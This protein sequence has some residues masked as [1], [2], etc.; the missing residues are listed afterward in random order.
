MMHAYAKMDRDDFALGAAT[1]I[2]SG[3]AFTIPSLFL[4]AFQDQP[5]P[6]SRLID[7]EIEKMEK[8]GEEDCYV[9][10]GASKT[11]KKET[12]WISKSKCLIV[13]YA[14]SFER[15]EGEYEIPEMT[16]E[17]LDETIRGMG[18]EVTEENR[19]SMRERM[20]KSK[21]TLKTAKLTGSSTETHANISSPE[22]WKAD[23]QFPLPEGA[24]LK[25]SLFGNAM[26]GGK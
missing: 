11:S 2:S 14:R 24:V 12:F 4:S 8:V 10:S 3:A 25:D 13:K 19:K 6:F 16:D 22:L 18:F 21:E 26:S 20:N 23:F 1:G 17:Q 9:I 5:A 7:P 15:P